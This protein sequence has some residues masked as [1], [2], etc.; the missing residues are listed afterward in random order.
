MNSVNSDIKRFA[1]SVGQN[2]Y[3]VVLIPKCRYP[4]FAQEHQRD[5][6]IKAIDTSMQRDI[7]SGNG[8]NVYVIDK[9]GVRKVATKKVDTHVK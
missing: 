4:V 2:W 1:H 7:A 8:I 6:A 9:N 5:L 3:H